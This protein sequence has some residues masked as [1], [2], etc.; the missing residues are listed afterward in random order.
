MASYEFD[1]HKPVILCRRFP[2]MRCAWCGLVY[3]KND[4]T[5]KAIKLGCNYADHPDWK[6]LF[7]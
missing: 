2:I 7:R 6:K 3:L 5:V 4:I 1:A